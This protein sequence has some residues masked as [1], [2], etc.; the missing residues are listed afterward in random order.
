MQTSMNK[1]ASL[2]SRSAARGSAVVGRPMAGRAAGVSRAGAVN[3]RAEKVMLL[4]AAAA[5]H[6]CSFAPPS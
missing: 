3:V 4:A 2:G 1:G 6:P 5:R